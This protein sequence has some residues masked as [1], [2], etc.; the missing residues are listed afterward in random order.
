MFKR[1]QDDVTVVSLPVGVPY[2]W[3]V[4]ATD[5]DLDMTSM[6]VTYYDPSKN[7]VGMNGVWQNPIALGKQDKATM[8][9]TSNPW[10][11]AAADAK[12]VYTLKAQITDANGNTSREMVVYVEYTD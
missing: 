6:V 9:Y 2:Y 1:Q 3:A 11:F 12:G 10:Y 7:I 8:T 5:P 4:N